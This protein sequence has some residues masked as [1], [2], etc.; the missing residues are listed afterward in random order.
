VLFVEEAVFS[1]AHGFG[2]VVVWT[3]F[4]AFYYVGLHTCLFF[5]TTLFLCI[6]MNFRIDFPV[7][8]KNV[9]DILMRIAF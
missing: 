2:A 9:I 5:N 3:Y 7:S 6:H 8:V 4:W 1:P